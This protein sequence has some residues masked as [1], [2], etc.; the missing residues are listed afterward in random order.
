MDIGYSYKILT[1]TNKKIYR[2]MHI[3]LVI[4]MQGEMIKIVIQQY[5]KK[6]LSVQGESP[7]IIIRLTWS[8][9]YIF[10]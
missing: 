8:Y 5:G 2:V 4:L 1:N 3:V 7:C 10:R 6:V 9:I